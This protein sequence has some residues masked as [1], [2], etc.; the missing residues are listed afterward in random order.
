M[1]V[2]ELFAAD[3]VR[4]RQRVVEIQTVLAKNPAKLEELFLAFQQEVRTHFRKEDEVYY[5]RVDAGKKINDRELIHHLRNDHAAVVFTLESLAIRLRK[6]VP[7][8]E[9]KTKFDAMIK[10]LLPHFDHEEQK[11]FPEVERTLPPATLQDLLDKV[12]AL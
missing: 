10:V 11:L 4:L 1:N 5:T 7:L 2:H 6:K 3:H 12:Q 8:E 9:W